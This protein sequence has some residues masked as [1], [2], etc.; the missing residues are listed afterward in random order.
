MATT[1]KEQKDPRTAH[2]LVSLI[3]SSSPLGS[4]STKPIT[5]YPNDDTLLSLLHARFRHDLPFTRLGSSSLVAV[6]PNKL[7]VADNET[8]MREIAEKAWD[9]SGRWRKDGGLQAHAFEFATR[10]YLAN[11]R[12]NEPQLVIPRGITA[13]GKSHALDLLTRQILHLSSSPAFTLLSSTGAR[14]AQKIA[15]Q[16]SAFNT[17]LNSFGRAKTQASPDASKYSSYTELHF[18]SSAEATKGAGAIVGAKVLTWGLDKSRLARLRQDERTFHIFY[19]LLSGASPSLYES[20]SLEDASE[21]AL[22]ASSGC[23]RLPSGPFSDDAAQFGVVQDAMTALGFKD[24][25]KEGVWR[26]LSALLT[27]GNIEFDEPLSK[28]DLNAGYL[29]GANGLGGN[30]VE[31]QEEV[32]ILNPGMLDRAAR[33]LGVGSEDLTNL[34]TVKSSYVR[35]EVFSTY[36]ELGGARRQRDALAGGLYTLLFSYIIETA[37]HKLNPAPSSSDSP[38]STVPIIFLDSPGYFTRASQGTGALVSSASGGNGFTEFSTNFQDE[39]I[40]S[41]VLRHDFDDNLSPSYAI[42]NDGIHLP[43]MTIMDNSTVIELLRGGLVT[44]D[45]KSIMGKRVAGVLG[46]MNKAATSIRKGGYVSGEEMVQELVGSFSTNPSFIQP[47]SDPF[48]STTSFAPNQAAAGLRRFANF[49]INHYAGPVTYG[50]QDW[51]EFD[52]DAWD[53]G[54]VRVL[55][56]SGDGFIK[57]LVSGPGIASESHIKDPNIV[58]RAQVSSRPIRNPSL[59]GPAN[60]DD[61]ERAYGLDPTKAY[62]LTTQFN[63][64]LSS[65]LSQLERVEAR[66]WTI[67]C[68]RPNDSGLSN[69]FDK[70]RVRAQIRSQGIVDLVGRKQHEWVEGYSYSD[71]L[72][73]SGM[74]SG[75][76]GGAE[77]GIRA[78]AS[79]ERWTEGV[80]FTFGKTKVWLSW[81]AWRDFDDRQRLT[82]NGMRAVSPSRGHGDEDEAH[83]AE[84]GEQS[85][86]HG[87]GG[88]NAGVAGRRSI[89]SMAFGASQEDLLYSR[90]GLASADPAGTFPAD[91]PGSQP[92]WNG[93]AEWEKGSAE[94]YAPPALTKG[95]QN[96]IEMSKS[97]G[98]N[99]YA[100]LAGGEADAST[101][102]VPEKGGK[103]KALAKPIEVIPTTRARRWWV[104][105]VWL[106]T[107][108]IPSFLLNYI[109]GMKRSDIR[110][111][112]REKVTICLLIFGLCASILFYVIVFGK[113]ICPEFD[114]AWNAD[115]LLG[116]QADDDFFVS[117]QGSVYDISKFW[118]SDHSVPGRPM[119]RSEVKEL[120][121]FDLSNY[122]PPP[123]DLACAGLV[124]STLLE[125]RI[126][127]STDEPIITNGIHTSGA[128]QTLQGS[129]L[130]STTWYVDKFLPKMKPMYKG[131][132]VW[133]KKQI[134][135]AVNNDRAIGI[136]RKEVY[137]LSDYVYT[138]NQNN[139]GGGYDYINGDVVDVFR[140]QTGQDI[141]K[142]LDSVLEGLTERQVTANMACLKNR[143]YYGKTDFRETPRCTIQGYLLVA[144]SVIIAATILVKF[145]AALQLTSKRSPELLDKFI[146]CQVP[147]YTEGEESLRRT[148]DSLA[149][150]KYDDK[151]KLL[152]IICDGN[153]VGSGNDRP[154]PRIV[155]DIL[156]VDPSLDPEPLMFRSIGEGSKQLNYGKIYSGL[157]EFEGHVVPYMVV[158]KVG[159]PSERQRPGNRG[160]RDSQILLLHYLNRVHFDAPMSPLEL[161][162]YHQMH[163]II[164]IDPAFYEYIFM[165]D[166]DTTVTPDS[167]NRLVAVTSDDSRVIA[168]C[169]ET[170]LDNEDGSWWTMIQVYEYYI[171]HHLAKAFE[172]LFGSVTCLPGCF[173]M[174]RIRTADKGRPLIISTRIIEEYSECNVDTLHKKNLLQLGEDRYLTTIMMKHFPLFKMKFTPDAIAHTVAPDRWSVLLSQR[175]RWINSTIHNLLELVGL[176]ELCGFCCFSMRFIVFVDLLGTL[177][178][179]ATAVYLV[180]LIVVVATHA[181]PLPV[182]SLAMIGAVYGLQAVIFLLKR[183]F[184]LIGWMIIYILAYPVYS[185]F[186]PIY[187]F[188]SMDDFSWGNTRIVVGEGRDRKV[189]IQDDEG[190]DENAIPLKKFSDYEAEALDQGEHHSVSG[191]SRPE[192][193]A[194][195]AVP[196]FRPQSRQG[197]QAGSGYPSPAGDYYRDTNITYNNSS[198]PNLRLPPV[199]PL[200]S[201]HASTHGGS[202]PELPHLPSMPF[203]GPGSEYGHSRMGSMAGMSMGPMGMPGATG[204]GMMGGP[205]EFGSFGYAGSGYGGSAYGGTGAP[206]APRNSVMTNLNMF[207]GSGGGAMGS[208]PPSSFPSMGTGGFGQQQR[209]MSTFSMATSINPLMNS[210]PSLN[211]NPSD[212]ELL[213]VLR[214][215]LSTQDLMTVTKKTAREAVMARFPKA[216]L[217]SK[218]DFLNQSI[219][220]ILS[221]T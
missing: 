133:G 218:K 183:E 49:G 104:R 105:F 210:A 162:M 58:V 95:G 217:S 79:G 189:I 8:S 151:R 99:G 75:I 101:A 24:R 1:T 31:G 172:S 171:S 65:L 174:Y 136:Y 32:R 134:D 115:E 157:Y 4:T 128:R 185:F 70:K 131:P 192:S 117:I 91:P 153:I 16:I 220:R 127:N 149:A 199:G 92:G 102:P 27:L 26:V 108:W 28:R 197:S 145:L 138:L 53:A 203:A 74:G 21:Y 86:H 56:G 47:I 122:F 10:I 167:L 181:S 44:A 190:F 103:G 93:S 35:K 76:A 22:L 50:V 188:W 193:R 216:D 2:D 43:S 132:L 207:G 98:K 25:H 46:V 84:G 33:L 187:S 219:E 9:A 67:Q 206:G 14:K 159:K 42:V 204:F 78:F 60:E 166:A 179:P 129:D 116:H 147:C 36:L 170:K 215:Y 94:G 82:E 112:W 119:I 178:L 164:G 69:S 20:M 89:G 52:A 81:D 62:P 19:Q 169:G 34:L 155:L 154:T 106:C 29:G 77:D 139:G 48:A 140:Q 177:I 191:D 11:T 182:V 168:V 209:P 23:Y 142:A 18:S 111:A 125:V 198:N 6:N 87:W 41:Y 184:M 12:F 68:I 163:N 211:P 143:F 30:A 59:F 40:Q 202:Q 176:G 118:K 72:A 5:I 196:P 201:L 212:E 110:M 66:L 124:A 64:V 148:I 57:R 37:N 97:G 130:L 13:S 146:I 141:T 195:S 54:F 144:F 120:A 165:V 88:R 161:E 85:E 3:T 38:E 205:G 39:I 109:G 121:G 80:D 90:G 107:W 194:R 114:H 173:S 156:G 100:N 45:E 51:V 71:F 7:I 17:L 175:R 113:L 135:R 213:S 63:S 137:D 221:E 96:A 55:R 15:S 180:Y 200:A 160:K 123:L 150:L 158:V 186:L 83:S 61:D 126:S 208:A 73:M 214:L 152:F